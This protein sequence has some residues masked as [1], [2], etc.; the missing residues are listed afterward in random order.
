MHSRFVR[1]VGNQRRLASGDLIK[2]RGSLLVGV[3][4]EA[5][6]RIAFSVAISCLCVRAD[7]LLEMAVVLHIWQDTLIGERD[8]DR[9]VSHQEVRVAS[10]T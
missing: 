5:L 2:D 8:R 4:G 6:A 3:G 7:H 9:N 10:R 1:Q